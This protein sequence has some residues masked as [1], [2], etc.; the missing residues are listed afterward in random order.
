MLTISP[1]LGSLLTRTTKTP[2]L[3]TALWKVLSEYVEMKILALKKTTT[4]LEEKWNMSFDEFSQRSRS[5]TLDKDIYSWETE[6]DFWAW[7]QA[8]T[9]LEHYETLES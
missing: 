9:L 3:E 6:Q 5:K 8:L 7:E 2:D 1:K 4:Q